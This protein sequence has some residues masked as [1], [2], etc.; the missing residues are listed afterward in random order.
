MSEEQEF[1]SARQDVKLDDSIPEENELHHEFPVD[2]QC[3]CLPGSSPKS[4]RST[5]SDKKSERTSL[6]AKSNPFQLIMHREDQM[7]KKAKEFSS[8][9]LS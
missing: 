4:Q 5:S 1:D 2:T 6:L 9:R 8:R 3:G 7:L